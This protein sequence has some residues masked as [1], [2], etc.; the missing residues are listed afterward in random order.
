FALAASLAAQTIVSPAS[1]VSA[2]GDSSNT[3]PFVGA[4]ARRYMQIHADLGAVPL[5]ITKLTFRVGA[6]TLVFPGTRTHDMELY[7]GEALPTAVALPSLTFDAN[8]ATPKTLVLPRQFVTFGPTGQS[9]SPG[10]NP[11]HPTLEI[12]LATPFV[13]SGTAPLI[14]EVAYY[15]S[16]TSG[17]STSSLDADGSTSVTATSTITGTGC[18][19]TGATSLMTHTYTVNDSRGTLLL[20]GTISNGP[21]NALAFMGIGLS[22]PGVPVPVLCSNLYT[23]VVVLQFLGV[24]SATGSFTGENP[25]GAL[26]LPNNAVGLALFTQAFAFDPLLSAP[27]PMVAS[28]GRSSLVP[29]V[30]TAEVNLVTRL[31]NNVGGTTATT[32][33]FGT[34]IVGYG[35]A[36]QFTHL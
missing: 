9:V 11:F 36:T 32:A 4:T 15:G 21:A 23:D 35:L 16:T 24:T 12:T 13:Y 25:T 34:S 19:A 33:A 30:G 22:N 31:W 29:A 26:I 7:M 5:V 18:M 17:G 6:S 27:F 14:W 8:Y 28:N 1:C 3:F 20:N 10:P 2:E